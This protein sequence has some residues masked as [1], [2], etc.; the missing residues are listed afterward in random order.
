MSYLSKFRPRRTIRTEMMDIML[1]TEE[2]WRGLARLELPTTAHLKSD[3]LDPHCWH[4]RDRG[5]GTW[6]KSALLLLLLLLHPSNPISWMMPR[7]WIYVLG[8]VNFVLINLLCSIIQRI[9]TIHTWIITKLLN[10]FSNFSDATL[11]SRGQKGRGEW[12]CETKKQRSLSG[13]DIGGSQKGSEL[14]SR[15]RNWNWCQR[16]L[17]HKSLISVIYRR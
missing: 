10:K 8:V 13:H 5:R 2:T 14:V 15:L 4:H 1:R 11:W 9:S 7:L 3:S 12:R 6:P 16:N 17:D